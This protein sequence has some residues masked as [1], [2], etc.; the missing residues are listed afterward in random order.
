MNWTKT[1]PTQEG[2]YYWRRNT[3]YDW[4]CRVVPEYEI[5]IMLLSGEWGGRVPAPGTS[6]TVE[7]LKKWINKSFITSGPIKDMFERFDD[8]QDGIAAV[9]ER[10]R[11]DQG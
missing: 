6:F 5:R 8:P 11:K 4:I 7:E 1:P 9:T 3:K 10:N 2:W